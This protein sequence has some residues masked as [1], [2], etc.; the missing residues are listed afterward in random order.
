[1]SKL[2]IAAVVMLAP[3][4]VLFSAEDPS[5]TD[6]SLARVMQEVARLR[7]EVRQLKIEYERFRVASLERELQQAVTTRLAVQTERTLLQQDLHELDEQ[8]RQPLD[9]E[10]YVNLSATRTSL[11]GDRAAALL[12]A[13]KKADKRESEIT[14]RLTAARQQLHALLQ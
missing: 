14:A 2:L 4:G 5:S 3:T 12:E 13:E 10:S 7:Q 1:M 8:L 11:A 6:N 9:T